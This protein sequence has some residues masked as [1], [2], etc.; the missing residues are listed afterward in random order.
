MGE[1]RHHALLDAE[2]SSEEVRHA[3][4]NLK[5]SK[6]PGIDGLPGGCLKLAAE[7]MMPFLTRLFNGTFESH[8]FPKSWSL[9]IIVPIH[10]KG[11]VLNTDNYRGIS[12][13]CAMCKV[14]TAIL[15]RRLRMWLEQENKICV[16]QAGFRTQHSTID[17]IFSLYSMVLK[18]VYGGG[19]GKLYVTFV[20]YRKAFDSVNRNRLWTIMENM[21]L[22]TKFLLML[23]AMY[24]NVQ[25][26]VRW[27]HVLSECFDS[28]VG[29]KQGALESPSIFAV[30]INSVAE[31]VN[32]KGRHGVQLLPGMAEIF[33]LLFADDIVLIST[34]PTGLQNQI[35]NLVHISKQL[36][37][38]VNLMK[39]KVMVFRKGGHLSAGERWYLDGNKLEV[40]NQYKYLGFLFTTKLSINATIEDVTDKGKQK[41][42]HVLRTLWNLQST[43]IPIFT[44]L[45]DSQVQ[46]S[47]LYGSEIWGTKKKRSTS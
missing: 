38:S 29:V 5:A 18:H 7:K 23:K 30:Y 45:F 15:A 17:H 6:A 9:S 34:T 40:V 37:L 2:I 21:G 36:D 1:L 4:R 43:R 27:R 11:D 10:K 35:D 41:G 32:R 14:F 31:Y 33:L 19:R 39:T 20:D 13:L 24:Q 44:K 3:V 22:S 16:E 26:C 12:L 28:L 42:V 47:L 25:S 8:V 46:P